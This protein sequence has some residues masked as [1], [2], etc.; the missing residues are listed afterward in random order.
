MGNE[1]GK[2]ADPTFVDLRDPALAAVLA[3]AVPGLGHLY[4]KRTAKAILFFVC[5]MSTFLYGLSLGKGRVVYA[6]WREGDKRLP[7]LCQVGTG[8]AAMP[9]LIQASRVR[10]GKEPHWNGFMAPPQLDSGRPKDLNTIDGLNYWFSRSFELGT[11]YTM[12]AGLLNILVIYDAWGGPV[13]AEDE[14]DEEDD[15]TE[16]SRDKAEEA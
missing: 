7:Y 2:A 15:E 3:W 4:Q 8:L 10:D 6:S 11:V 5:I 13:F 9:A 14:D 1:S 16:P 12:V